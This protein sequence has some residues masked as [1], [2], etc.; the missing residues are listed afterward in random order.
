MSLP[1]SHRYFQQHQWPC[2]QARATPLA[3]HQWKQMLASAQR[4]SP[5]HDKPADAASDPPGTPNKGPESSRLDASDRRP[6]SD[7]QSSGELHEPQT[8]AAS[9]RPDVVVL[10][11]RNDYE[12]DAGHFQGAD[13]PQEEKFNETPT[14]ASNSDS[15]PS[16]SDSIPSYLQGKAADTPVMMYCTGGIRCDVYSAH[17]RDKGFTNLYMLEGGIQNYL[18]EE[19]H[20]LWDGSLFVFDGRMAVPSGDPQH[21]GQLVA[22]APCAACG[23]TASLPHMNCANIDCNKLFLACDQHKEEFAGCC[24]QACLEAP[25][26]LRPPKQAGYYGNWTTYSS[27]DEVSKA[28]MIKGRGSGRLARRRKRIDKMRA[29]EAL[30]REERHARKELVKAAMQSRQQSDHQDENHDAQ[31]LDAATRRMARLSVLRHQQHAQAQ[32]TSV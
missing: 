27:D 22:A 20:Q 23:E 18:R 28:S 25:R 5:S 29:K 2:L 14:E 16:N 30:A 19:G 17:L 1:L 26:L 32:L 9:A 8:S 31:Q 11:V 3:P 6:D 13:R 12:W 24:S 15:I 4:I 10:D 7:A 21:E